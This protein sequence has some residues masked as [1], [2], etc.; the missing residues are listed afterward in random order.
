MTLNIAGTTAEYI[1]NLVRKHLEGPRAPALKMSVLQDEIRL[2]GDW[3]YVP[4]RADE[5]P[6]RSSQYY[7]L[8]AELEEEIDEEEDQNIL[9]VPCS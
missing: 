8:L 7:T 5:Q 6:V 1:A 2:D 9:L 4:V 3:W